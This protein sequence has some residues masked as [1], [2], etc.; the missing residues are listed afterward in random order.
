MLTIDMYPMVE[1][2][3]A[4]MY[5]HVHRWFDF[6]VYV[7][8]HKACTRMMLTWVEADANMYIHANTGDVNC[9]S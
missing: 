3:N 9:D 2:T 5:V 4:D 6:G 7:H 1:G 8:R